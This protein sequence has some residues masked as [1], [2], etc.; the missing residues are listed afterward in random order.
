MSGFLSMKIPLKYRNKTFV[1]FATGPSL[2]TEVIERLRPFKDEFIMLGCNDCYKVVDYLHEHYA[3][4]DKWWRHHGEELRELR[5]KLSSWSQA[6]QDLCDQYQVKHI[7]G[8]HKEGLSLDSDYIHYGSNSGFQ[9][10]NLAFL[11]GGSRF[12]LVGYNMQI[13]GSL[14]HYFGDHP[15]GLK[16]SSP[17]PTFVKAYNNIQPEIK[18]LIINC[19]PDSALTMFQYQNLKELLEW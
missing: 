9:G 14:T 2:T 19:T 7:D 11:M 17:Y 8:K 16:T 13:V 6:A 18:E 15:Q 5:P 4:D 12:L 1:L 3:C 10:L